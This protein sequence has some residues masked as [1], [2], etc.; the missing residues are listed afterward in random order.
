MTAPTSSTRYKKPVVIGGTVV[1]VALGGFLVY[2]FAASDGPEDVAWSMCESEVESRAKYG[3]MEFGDF[4]ANE[5][6]GAFWFSGEVD[7]RNGYGGIVPHSFEC[8]IDLDGPAWE[9]TVVVTA[10]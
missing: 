2:D 5:V 8:R 1:A 3:G 7:L 4:T 10:R 9:N 6:G